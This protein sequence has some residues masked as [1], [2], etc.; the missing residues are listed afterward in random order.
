[1][2]D[3]DCSQLAGGASYGNAGTQ[4]LTGNDNTFYSTLE[5]IDSGEVP[6]RAMAEIL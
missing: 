3:A 5:R 1:M 6:I 4:C 2:L